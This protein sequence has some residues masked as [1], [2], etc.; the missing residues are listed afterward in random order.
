MGRNPNP[1]D[2]LHSGVFSMAPIMAS[3]PG[4]FLPNASK[5]VYGSGI[6]PCQQGQ[7]H[8][9]DV[10]QGSYSTLTDAPDLL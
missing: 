2:D 6:N 5:L 9:V 8:E 10:Q 4:Q 3:R 7:T 1:P